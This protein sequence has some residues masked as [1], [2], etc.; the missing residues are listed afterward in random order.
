MRCRCAA[1]QHAHALHTQALC[2]CTPS[3]STCTPTLLHC[4]NPCCTPHH[5]TS[6]VFIQAP[7]D[8]DAAADA[9]RRLADELDGVAWMPGLAWLGAGG[10]MRRPGGRRPAVRQALG[11]HWPAPLTLGFEAEE[12]EELCAVPRGFVCPIT[13]TIMTQPAL[14]ISSSISVPA[15]YEKA[16][17]TR[18][19]Q[20]SR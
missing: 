20:E 13:Q 11:S 14:L 6:Q 17:I 16:A 8:L 3:A 12:V 15:T 9:L 19:L 1:K 18:W 4:S 2:A 7:T 10:L 5:T